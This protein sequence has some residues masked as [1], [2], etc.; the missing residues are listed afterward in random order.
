MPMYSESLKT[1][2][3]MKYGIHINGEESNLLLGKY[4]KIIA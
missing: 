4:I 1:K 2:I 3:Q